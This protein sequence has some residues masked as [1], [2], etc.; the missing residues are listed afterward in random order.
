[1]E[2]HPD[3]GRAYAYLAESLSILMELAEGR[4]V[5]IPIDPSFASVDLVSLGTTGKEVPP[6]EM[7]GEE[8]EEQIQLIQTG[9]S[10]K[11]NAGAAS[12]SFHKSTLAIYKNHIQTRKDIEVFSGE[13]ALTACFSEDTS[14]IY[15]TLTR[16]L[17]D[18]KSYWNLPDEISTTEQLIEFFQYGRPECIRGKTRPRK[19][20]YRPAPQ[21][22]RNINQAGYALFNT[23]SFAFEALHNSR[24]RVDP[25][26]HHS[27]SGAS[28]VKSG[29][30]RVVA[31]LNKGTT[32]KGKRNQKPVGFTSANVVVS[33]DTNIADGNPCTSK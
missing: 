17:E 28:G 24:L 5:V 27:W 2:E 16:N 8:L 33:K 14:E 26:T 6:S 13:G 18:I 15:D 32:N 30:A 29:R 12:S 3:T 1:L 22:A 21:K 19:K 9:V 23:M 31:V 25:T 11:R 10:V 4:T 7:T 20:E